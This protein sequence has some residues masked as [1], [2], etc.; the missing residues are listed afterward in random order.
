MKKKQS[1]R[2]AVEKNRIEIYF[3]Y[4]YKDIHNITITDVGKNP[5]G[6]DYIDGYANGDEKLNFSASVYDKH[7]ENG[8][9]MSAELGD[10]AKYDVD[11]SVSEIEILE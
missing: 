5:M 9:V 11:K 8:I 4:N 10:L 2:I 1:D 3:K 7:F 6:T